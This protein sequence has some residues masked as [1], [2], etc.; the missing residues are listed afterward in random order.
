M[1]YFDN[2]ATSYPKPPEV[3]RAIYKTMTERGGNPGRSSHAL[4]LAAAKAVYA[5]REAIAEHFGGNPEN[6][7]FTYNA[8]YALNLAIKAVASRY[9]RVLISDIEHNAVY[10]PVTALTRTGIGCDIFHVSENPAETY[11]SFCENLRPD[12]KIAAVNLASNVCGLSVPAEMIGKKCRES[13]TVFIADASQ[14]AGSRRIDIEKSCIDI[15][16]APGHKGLYGPQGCGFAL[17]GSA[18]S[19]ENA[20]KLKTFVEGG[21]GTASLERTMPAYLPER[22]EAGTVS[23]PAIAG[24]SAGL[25]CVNRFGV[26]EIAAHEKA[27]FM[28]AKDMI[29]QFGGIKIYAPESQGSTLLFNIDG[30]E[31][32]EVAEVF[33]GAEICVRAGFHCAPLPHSMLKTGKSGAVRVSFGIYNR[34]TD[35]ESFY[36]TLRRLTK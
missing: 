27:L 22:F 19:G 16:C 33:D 26:E 2:A 7:V 13:G 28:R 24:L 35:L 21:S 30:I 9:G 10:R 4:S 36:R 3:F 14:C 18:Y 31:P 32:S 23:T 34:S 5:C 6:I 12:T 11:R 20:A 15:L 29:S 1:I 17:F 8:T 25:N